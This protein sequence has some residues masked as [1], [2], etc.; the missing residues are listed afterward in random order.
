MGGHAGCNHHHK[1]KN[2]RTDLITFKGSTIGFFTGYISDT[3]WMATLFDIFIQLVASIEKDEESSMPFAWYSLM[4]GLFI[5][6][7]TA[8]GST[9]SHWVL[10]RNH[11]DAEDSHDT[12]HHDHHDHHDETQQCVVVVDEATPINHSD[13]I[14]T[15]NQEDKG[16]IRLRKLNCVPKF[17]EFYEKQVKNISKCFRINCGPKFL[18]RRIEFL[19]KDVG[20]QLIMPIW[21]PYWA[22][23][24][25]DVTALQ[26]FL[27]LGDYV[28]HTGE[29]A[30]PLTMLADLFFGSKMSLGA[31]LGVHVA[32]TLIGAEGSQSNVR[33]CYRN[34]VKSNKAVAERKFNDSMHN[35]RDEHSDSSNLKTLGRIFCCK[36]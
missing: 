28:S 12:C 5:A 31:K 4:F 32:A 1:E 16:A 29:L 19:V 13:N 21:L 25:R 24:G 2:Q 34:M 27:L 14:Y 36:I 17:F 8:A 30:G 18:Q 22:V 7:I 20:N 26:K 35:D 9:Y 6:T 10:D 15:Q 3:Y 33:T 11:Q 23:M